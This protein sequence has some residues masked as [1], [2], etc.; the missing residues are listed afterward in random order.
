MDNSTV[1]VNNDVQS[2]KNCDKSMK[3]PPPDIMSIAAQQISKNQLRKRRVFQDKLAAR[4]SSR[5]AEHLRRRR[6]DAA[7]HRE[8][9]LEAARAGL[10]PPSS[11]RQQRSE[12][13]ERLRSVYDDGD[14]SVLPP[15]PTVCIDLSTVHGLEEEGSGLFRPSTKQLQ[16][17]Q[18]QIVRAYGS[19][20]RSQ[21][22]L[23]LLLTSCPANSPFITSCKQ[24][25]EGFDRFVWQV[26]EQSPVQLFE[27]KRVVV[28][29]PDASSRLESFTR[30]DVLVIGGVVDE[31]VVP[32][33][34]LG[35]ASRCPG[36]RVARLPLDL[37][38]DDVSESRAKC[39]NFVLTV[40]QV[41]DALLSVWQK[42]GNW[43]DALK[44]VVPAR[45]LRL[46][47]ERSFS[48]LNRF[49]VS[50]KVG[51]RDNRPAG[52]S[53]VSTVKEEQPVEGSGHNKS[54][55]SDKEIA[56]IQVE[57]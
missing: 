4:R 35:H 36:V 41:F 40:N 46:E 54:E 1:T 38:V 26:L 3:I 44:E 27:S 43:A 56:D 19:N 47:S 17:L 57:L 22:P 12:Q 10:P 28:L 25:F 23:R 29:S 34:M 37:L 5:A 21:Q 42:D 53:N 7:T 2:T 16:R 20:R 48:N 11:R 49:C 39:P 55:S 24:R 13:L 8:R 45:K 32:G 50:D 6:R 52:D 15:C 9:A 14:Q 33:V 31:T 51:I 30:E 18:Q